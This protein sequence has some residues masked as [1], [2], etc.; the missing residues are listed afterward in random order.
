MRIYFHIEKNNY[1]SMEKI[2]KIVSLKN[3][4]ILATDK[5]RFIAKIV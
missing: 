2:S 5:N 3:K 4:F 1:Y